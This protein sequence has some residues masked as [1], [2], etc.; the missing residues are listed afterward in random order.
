MASVPGPIGAGDLSW[1]GKVLVAFILDD[2]STLRALE[3]VAAVAAV[4]S[5]EPVGLR[6]DMPALIFVDRSHLIRPHPIRSGGRR[7]H[8]REC[9]RGIE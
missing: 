1:Y 8:S 6:T 7:K 2:Q 3:D 9:P 4:R 5:D